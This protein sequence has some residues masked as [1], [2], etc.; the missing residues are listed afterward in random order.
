[1]AFFRS[2]DEPM[3]YFDYV[4]LQLLDCP[5]VHHSLEA[6]PVHINKGTKLAQGINVY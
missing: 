2:F 4:P 6:A 3:R 1:M 5:N